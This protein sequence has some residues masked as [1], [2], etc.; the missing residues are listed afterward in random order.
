MNLNVPDS[1][2]K[3]V[4]VIGGGFAG[5]TFARKIDDG[6][7][8]T[9]LIDRN[10]Y[11]QFQP[12][13]YQVASSG[14]EASSICFSL[15][16]IFR[17]KKDL[18]VRVAEV[19][20]IDG[21][22]R[23]VHTS[24]GDIT[25][26]YLVLCA[27]A[28][29][30]FWGNANME[31]R[32]LPMKTV[33]EA[34]YLRNRIIENCEKSLTVP[35]DQMEPYLNIVIVGGGATGVEIAGVLCEMRKFAPIRDEAR[36]VMRKTNIHLVGPGI[37]KSMSEQASMKT[38]EALEELGVNLIIGHKVVD[39]V[40]DNVI[41]DDG[42]TILSKLLIWVSGV[43]AVSID[44]IPASS[45]G[46][47]GRIVCDQFMRI[48]GMD[49][50]FS[51]GDISITSEEAYPKGH[52]QLAQ[53]A[54]QQAST[55]AANLNAI[56]SGKETKPFRYRDLGSMATIGRNKA[57]ADIGSFHLSGF[58]AWIIWMVVHLRSILGV[59]NK[60]IVLID[61]I[62]NY[63]NFRNSMKLLLFKGRR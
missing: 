4:V 25:Y 43:K 61:W 39:Y 35:E 31:R 59:R 38:A 22:S 19:E 63:I 40:D 44:G 60:I 29:T 47:G 55:I 37:L 13:I 27:G 52:P 6:K 62:I 57:V 49:D 32:A 34:M 18:Y 42:T 41:L 3:R 16:R 12:L 36:H 51:A 23:T 53:V 10:N 1:I 5:I 7:Y 21:T 14:L 54:M 50:A 48:A 33:E 56:A 9:V 46:H 58:T 11:H 28:T 45:I 24:E 8:Q 15:R 2:K 26:D 30:N 17:R 20:G